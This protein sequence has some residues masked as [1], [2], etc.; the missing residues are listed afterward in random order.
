MVGLVDVEGGFEAL[1]GFVVP[2]VGGGAPGAGGGVEEVGEVGA[3]EALAGGEVDQGLRGAVDVE[4]G[5]EAVAGPLDGGEVLAG[6]EGGAG[7]D[8]H[9]IEDGVFAG[10]AGEIAGVA[11]AGGTFVLENDAPRGDEGVRGEVGA[12]GGEGEGVQSQILDF[13]C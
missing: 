4:D 9:G 5:L 3:A 2:G 11:I 8:E 7:V 12:A 13:R 6:L 10:A 1:E